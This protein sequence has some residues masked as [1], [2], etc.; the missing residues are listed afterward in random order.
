[1]E[2]GRTQKIY[3][4]VM[5]IIITAL[6]SSLVTTIIV[7]ERLTSSSSINNIASGDGT[8]G[9]EKTLASIRTMLEKG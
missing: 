4:I 1:M 9:I 7:K 3:K 6:L 8:T 2:T 5:L